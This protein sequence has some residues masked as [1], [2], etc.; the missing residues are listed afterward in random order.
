MTIPT[1]LALL[2]ALPLGGCAFALPSGTVPDN[3][4]AA[5]SNDRAIPS[6]PI[7]NGVI[8]QNGTN[9]ANGANM[10]NGT[11]GNVGATT[12]AARTAA[13]TALASRPLASPPAAG[14]GGVAAEALAPS[15]TR[16][17]SLD[18]P[19]DSYFA[20]LE[21]RGL[22]KYLVRCALDQPT[23]PPSPCQVRRSPS[24]GAPASPRS[25]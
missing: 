3:A 25:G 20:G 19:T 9:L 7:R 5:S 18:L 10:A 16:S 11:T 15:S 24:R 4:A 21:G 17:F 23:L 6:G 22:L 14:P 2:F 12:M 13:L 1:A 8:L